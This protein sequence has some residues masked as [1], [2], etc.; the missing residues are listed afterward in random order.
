MRKMF[1]LTDENIIQ[2]LKFSVDAEGPSA[3]QLDK[4]MAL[5]QER[6]PGVECITRSI[7]MNAELKK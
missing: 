1:G 2:K 4:L 7:P 5:T 3:E 6:C